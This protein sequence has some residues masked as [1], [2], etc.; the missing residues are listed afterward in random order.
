VLASLA[1]AALLTNG[2]LLYQLLVPY[3]HPLY[4]PQIAL[5]AVGV[6]A[7][8][9]TWPRGGRPLARTILAVVVLGGLIA[10]TWHLRLMMRP[11]AYLFGRQAFAARVQALTDPDALVIFVIRR[12][13][14]PISPEDYR[15][16]TEQGE[17]L[18]SD[19]RDFYLSHRKGYSIDD[20]Q[21]TP[22]FVEVL[23]Q[24]GARYLATAEAYGPLDP[25]GETGVFE[26]FPGLRDALDQR[27]RPLEVTKRWAIYELIE[28]RTER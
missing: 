27:Y 26:R 9:A 7:L 3:R 19:P 24:R 25:S 2:W 22:E 12:E 4:L 5:L 1:I 14:E 13:W 21:A 16:R 20:V 11:R 28:P 6:V 17:M 15:H 8:A 18:Y 10:S 23:R